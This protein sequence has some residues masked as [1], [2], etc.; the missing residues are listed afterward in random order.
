M[1]LLKKIKLLILEILEI[2]G[3]VMKNVRFYL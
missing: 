1:N 3:N 2:D